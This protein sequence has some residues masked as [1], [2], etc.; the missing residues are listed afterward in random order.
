[1]KPL[2]M[3]GNLG[4]AA[5]GSIVNVDLALSGLRVVNGVQPSKLYVRAACIDLW[6]HLE[7]TSHRA[8]FV[9]GCPGVGKSVEV[10][11]YAMW[12]T[13][14]H[15]KRVLYIHSHG[16]SYSLIATADAGSTDV[17]CGRVAD[18]LFQPPQVLLDFILSSMRRG[19][20]DVIVLDGQLSWLIKSVFL[21]LHQC[22]DVRF[23]S[24]TSFQ[25]VS[26]LSTEQLDNAPEFSE[27]LMDSWV[28][29]EYVA[30]ISAGALVLDTT[31]GLTVEEMFFYA[32]GSVRMIQWSVKSVTDCLTRKMRTVSDMSKLIGKQIVGVSSESAVNT[33]MAMYSGY[34]TVLSRYVLTELIR[35]LSTAAILAI[36]G[37]LPSNASWQGW[38]TEL[39]VL[40]LAKDRK[41]TSF[42][43]PDGESEQWPRHDEW[44]VGEPLFEFDNP[45]EVR[46]VTEDWL[47]PK[48]WNHACFDGLYRTPSGTV[49]AIQITIAEKHGC[50]LKHLIP[51]AQ[52]MNA[53]VVELV[54][55]CRRS[56]FDRFKV[57]TPQI[58]PTSSSSDGAVEHG[59]Y[60]D[61]ITALEVIWRAKN[62][63]TIPPPSLVIRKL[64]YEQVY[65]DRPLV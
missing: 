36:R 1:M 55:V 58:E 7:T 2:S 43:R 46:G 10:Y 15:N 65:L 64:C 9:T 31:T 6:N 60:L 62:S 29:E 17:R 4:A 13:T 19:A 54:Y 25:A 14:V 61:L 47:L 34:S 56:N 27:F 44:R 50:K 18:Y 42:R 21:C 12:Q 5:V 45:S 32:G 38:V 39:E 40:L 24:C 8:S 26:E 3:Q 53:H 20:V 51:I 35:T 49:R 33:L 22:Q 37:I 63:A 52:A 28:Q 23:I 41:T 59:Q 57:P 16:G 30:A 48:R 11:A